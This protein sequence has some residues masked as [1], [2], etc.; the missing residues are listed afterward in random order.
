MQYILTGKTIEK[1]QTEAKRICS[2]LSLAYGF[3]ITE[4][5]ADFIKFKTDC[6][7][8]INL[9]SFTLE[10]TNYQQKVK[11]Q[12]CLVETQA[13]TLKELRKVASDSS[14]F[15]NQYSNL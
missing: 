13:V 4:L 1:I 6:Y 2:Y 15:I 5:V 8:L 11:E 3:R 10:Q 14:T 9:K 7:Y 12:L